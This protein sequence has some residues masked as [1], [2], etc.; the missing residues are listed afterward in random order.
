MISDYHS[1]VVTA[2]RSLLVNGNAKT[3]L[4][5]D[6]KSLGVKP[7]KEVVDKNLKSKNT[8]NFSSIQNTFIT[9]LHKHALPQI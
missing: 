5:R 4:Y 3:K 7:F 2:L 9:V 6:Y 8:G 1:L